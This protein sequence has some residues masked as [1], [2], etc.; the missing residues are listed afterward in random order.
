MVA[1][2]NNAPSALGCY[3]RSNQKRMMWPGFKKV[4]SSRRTGPAMHYA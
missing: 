4:F 2:H 3:R 1:Q